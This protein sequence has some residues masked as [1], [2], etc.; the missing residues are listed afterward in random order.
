MKKPRVIIAMGESAGGKSTLLEAIKTVMKAK[1]IGAKVITD[2]FLLGQEV[3]ADIR[4]EDFKEGFVKDKKVMVGEDSYVERWDDDPEKIQFGVLHGG[5]LNRVHEKMKQMMV[6]WDD[7]ETVLLMEWTTGLDVEAEGFVLATENAEPLK[8]SGESVVELLQGINLDEAEVTI[9]YIDA[10]FKWREERNRRRLALREGGLPEEAFAAYFPDGGELTK[11]IAEGLPKG[12]EFIFY[13]NNYDG[14][15][16][17]T[18]EM[19]EIALGVIDGNRHVEGR[20][21]RRK[22]S[23]V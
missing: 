1:V 6:E 2:R 22:E 9:V 20:I 8:Q 10:E 11:E 18:K 13:D 23:E 19:L 14:S 4:R 17:F 5:P 3:Q 16:R 7:P 21:K 12:V 15:E